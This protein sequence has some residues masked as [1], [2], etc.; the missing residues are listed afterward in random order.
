MLRTLKI[1]TNTKGLCAMD[2]IE[3]F[4]LQAKNFQRDYKTQFAVEGDIGIYDYKPRF[5]E[6]INDIILSY[7][8]DEDR[9]F[10]LMQIQ[11]LIANLADFTSWN[12]LLRT[13]KQGNIDR[14]ELGKLLLDNRT[15]FY[16]GRMVQTLP[17]WEHT[18]H[19]YETMGIYFDDISK[20]QL[21]K[22]IFLSED[23]E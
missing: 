13:Y 22:E 9:P 23:H 4:K 1:K 6:D 8:I 5:F 14:L 18:L 19:W 3:Y 17:E 10:S 2:Y 20:L 15:V 11:H 16:D 7:E 21:F 12:D